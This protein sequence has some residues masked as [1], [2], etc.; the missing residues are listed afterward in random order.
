MSHLNDSF[1]NT[2]DR[3]M[4]RMSS[5]LQYA[6]VR[7]PEPPPARCHEC[8]DLIDE[9]EYDNPMPTSCIPCLDAEYI[10]VEDERASCDL[11]GLTTNH[12]HSPEEW[13]TYYPNDDK[14]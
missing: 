6:G 7:F 14:A 11:C 10:S 4:A 13:G 12:R 3:E 2:A 9:G 5:H 1:D 8:D